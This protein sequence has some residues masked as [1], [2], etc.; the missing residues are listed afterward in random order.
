MLGVF[1]IKYIPRTTIKG[2][3]LADLVAEFTKGA[4][5]GEMPSPEISVVS[6][7]CPPA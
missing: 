1:D 5:E 3:V 2:E 4:E 7:P 6:T